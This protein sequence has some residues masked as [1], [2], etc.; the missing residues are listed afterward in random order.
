MIRS[1]F[2]LFFVSLCCGC[3]LIAPLY[4][5]EPVDLPDLPKL[6]LDLGLENDKNGLSEGPQPSDSEESEADGSESNSA[7]GA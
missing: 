4:L 2:M 1:L 5:I 7:S 6:P 3:S